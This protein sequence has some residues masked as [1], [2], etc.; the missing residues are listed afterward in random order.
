MKPINIDLGELRLIVSYSVTANIF[1]IVDQISEWS[2]FCHK[3]Y[4]K[5]F[6][7]T[8][9]FTQQDLELLQQYRELREKRS[10]G[11]GLE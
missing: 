10:W 7:D 11:G 1:H 3:Q 4:I 2:P 5:Y 6:Q 9:G 8:G